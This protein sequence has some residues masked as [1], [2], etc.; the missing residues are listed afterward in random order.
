MCLTT[1]LVNYSG[2][3][4]VNKIIMYVPCY[5]VGNNT[6]S[7]LGKTLV[8][9][10][11]VVTPVTFEHTKAHKG[12]YVITAQAV[13]DESANVTFFWSLVQKPPKNFRFRPN[14]IKI[15][16]GGQK[17]SLRWNLRCAISSSFS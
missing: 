11:G 5:L 8:E 13:D 2:P 15:K 17:I 14:G 6:S 10:T 4:C 9:Y 16:T 12:L 7:G 3:F 1:D